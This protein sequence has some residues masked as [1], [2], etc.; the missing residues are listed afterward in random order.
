MSARLCTLGGYLGAGKT[1]LLNALLAS[2]RLGRAA[3]IVNDFGSVN[4]DAALI[5]A[6]D[7]DVI[8]LANGCVCCQISTDFID[9]MNAIRDRGEF[10]AVICEVS[11]VGDPGEMRRWGRVPGFA[12]GPVVT[13]VDALSVAKSVRDEYVGDLVREQIRTADVLVLSRGDSCGDDAREKALAV[14]AE[15]ASGVPVIPWTAGKELP[16]EL[17]EVLVG[18][19]GSRVGFRSESGSD[20]GA[21][22]GSSEAGS[23]ADRGVGGGDHD[24]V[25]ESLILSLPV[26]TDV[27]QVLEVLRDHADSLARAKGHVIVADGQMFEV[28]LA[29]G[30]VSSRAVESSE[31]LPAETS[32]V[33]IAAGA[34]AERAITK[35]RDAL[36]GVGLGDD[37][38]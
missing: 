31:P 35:A 25:H 24:V 36:A 7:D 1:T 8:S 23:S 11:G 14:V 4:I 18:E 12:P 16:P 2:G 34:T 9:T 10:D 26:P 20:A 38:E 17:I 32:L 13:V 27:E 37:L 3:V 21:E 15:L 6:V 5:E 28:H 33:L 19:G 29:G 30:Q 22:A